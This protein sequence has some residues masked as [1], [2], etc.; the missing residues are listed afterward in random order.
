MSS[1]CHRDGLV[2]SGKFKNR[3]AAMRDYEEELIENQF[4]EYEDDD[5]WDDA[6]E[7]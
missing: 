3:T 4:E 2:C 7:L 6:M 1:F 5:G